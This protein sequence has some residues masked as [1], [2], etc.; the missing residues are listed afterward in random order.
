LDEAVEAFEQSVGD[1]AV[2]PADHP[3]LVILE[4]R[5]EL[6]QWLESAGSGLRD[7]AA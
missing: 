4:H 2:M 3:E 6:G 5:A 7:P 1:A